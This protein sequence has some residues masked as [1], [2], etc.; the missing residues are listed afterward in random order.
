[1]KKDVKDLYPKNQK[2]LLIEIKEDLHKW[3]HDHGS[4]D[5]SVKVLSVPKLIL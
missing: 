5:L 4:E 1:M 3:I 2:S